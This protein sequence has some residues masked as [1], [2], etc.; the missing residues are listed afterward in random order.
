AEGRAEGH[1]EGRAE[2]HAEGLD[3]GQLRSARNLMDRLGCS[4]EKALD[5][6]GCPAP[7]IEAAA[8]RCGVPADRIRERAG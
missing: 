3:E 6:V 8:A 1:A 5:L 7:D 2:G 4:F